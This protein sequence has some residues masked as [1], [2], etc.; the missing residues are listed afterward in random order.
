MS[1]EVSLALSLRHLDADLIWQLFRASLFSSNII[2]QHNFNL[3]TYATLWEND[4]FD[5]MIYII[6][7]W[8]TSGDQITLFVF[9]DFGSLLSKFSWDDNLA[10]FNI[11]DLHDISN[12]EH[13]SWSNWGLLHDLGFK[14][15]SLSVGRESFIENEI[16]FKD[17]IASWESISLG[18]QFLIFVGS[19]TIMTYGR[20]SIDNLDDNG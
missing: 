1:I 16:K 15:L 9:L 3:E 10:S 14:K 17:N 13:G 18:Q 12:D 2:W 8:L 19:V 11:L 6:I 7:F 20:L 5:S 4:V